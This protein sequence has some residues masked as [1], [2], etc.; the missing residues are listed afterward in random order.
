MFSLCIG[1]IFLASI[2]PAR[3]IFGDYNL[4]ACIATTT[5]LSLAAYHLTDGGI[6]EFKTTL[7][8][9]GLFGKDLNKSGDKKNE[10]K[11]KM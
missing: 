3:N 4:I 10:A 2:H 8:A 6:T 9:K 11:E 5:L 7:M 1:G